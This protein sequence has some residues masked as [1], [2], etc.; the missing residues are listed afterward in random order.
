[1]I[2]IPSWK[3]IGVSAEDAVKP[4]RH[5]VLDSGSAA[6][7]LWAPGGDGL[8]AEP[9]AG[10]TL[11]TIN[12]DAAEIGIF[13]DT[14]HQYGPF[15]V[16]TRELQAEPLVESEWEDVVEF[17]VTTDH[18]LEISEPE[19]RYPSVAVVSSPGAYRI[20]VSARGRRITNNDFDLADDKP[21]EWYLVE[22]WPAPVAPGS[23]IRL[24]SPVAAAGLAGPPQRRD[25]PGGE[26]GLAAARRVGR[27]VDQAP[28]ARDLSGQTGSLTIE[29]TINGA[30]RRWYR[31]FEAHLSW[32]NWYVR[33]G[34]WFM[35]GRGL[36]GP[37]PVRFGGAGDHAEDQLT[38]E[39][40]DI[41]VTVIESKRPAYLVRGW[42]WLRQPPHR[43]H[44]R[45]EDREPLLAN[46][47]RQTIHL[48]ES[49][50]ANGEVWTHVQI[51]HAGLPVE[52]VEDMRAWWQLQL[53][54]AEHTLL[55]RSRL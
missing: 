37:N 15:S 17:S 11:V 34:G 23:V 46:D 13:I 19:D 1:M 51:E 30:R 55:D 49:K 7:V 43:S 21:I 26:D 10:N 42:N 4:E 8:T 5:L 38:G 27:D 25:I 3:A 39:T 12:S 35:S 53:A 28:G 29:W 16:T 2:A 20:R 22:A 36:D 47:A 54:I 14:G 6:L 24:T 45:H 18:S 50:D 32:S 44:I 48:T 31:S 40:A 33:T 41:R 52:W 9:W